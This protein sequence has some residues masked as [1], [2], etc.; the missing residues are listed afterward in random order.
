MNV[1]SLVVV[2]AAAVV[3]A[4]GAPGGRT[5]D[6]IIRRGTVLDGTGAAR[7]RADVGISGPSIAAIGDLSK[8][9]API[10]I[11]AS[12]LFVAPGFINLHSHDVGS[13]SRRKRR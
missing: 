1:R 4:Q 7:Y 2:L 8:A 11:D 3:Q 12:G 13:A 6:L 5:F 9:A 10:D